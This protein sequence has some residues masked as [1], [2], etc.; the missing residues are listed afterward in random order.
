MT[1]REFNQITAALSEMD[2][3]QINGKKYI[4][5]VGI[6]RLLNAFLDDKDH[7]EDKLDMVGE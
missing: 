6:L 2:G 4:S 3:F 5:Y 1:K 7:I